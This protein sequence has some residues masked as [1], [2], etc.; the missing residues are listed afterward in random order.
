MGHGY[1]IKVMRV[2]MKDAGEISENLVWSSPMKT[3]PV[4]MRIQTL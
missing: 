1:G 3:F 2:L 4:K